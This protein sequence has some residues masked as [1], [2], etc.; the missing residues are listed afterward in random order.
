MENNLRKIKRLMICIFALLFVFG[1]KSE[2][3]KAAEDVI[4]NPIV[5]DLDGDGQVTSSDY[6]LMQ[7]FLLGKISSFPVE[8]RVIK[9]IEDM[10]VTINQF[11]S[12][13]LPSTISA[14]MMDGSQNDLPVKWNIG[15]IDTNICDTYEVLGTV[16]GYGKM[17]NL[18]VTVSPTI[19]SIDN[20]NLNVE[21]DSD[22]ILPSKVLAKL[23]DGSSKEVNVTW[24]NTVDTSIKGIFTFEGTV[25]NYLEKV[26]YIITIDDLND[27]GSSN[28]NLLNGGYVAYKD[29]Y[30]YYANP[31]DSGKLYKKNIDGS[32]VKLTNDINTS[33]INIV[34][35]W[36]Y[37]KYEDAVYKV[38]NDGTGRELLTSSY[39]IQDYGVK[40][41]TSYNGEVY[42]SHQNFLGSSMIVKIDREGI[43]SRICDT[44]GRNYYDFIADKEFIYYKNE[45]DN[46]RLYKIKTDGSENSIVI[47]DTNINNFDIV[48]ND[49]IYSTGNY[50]KKISLISGN[51]TILLYDDKLSMEDMVI[52]DG[53]IYFSNVGSDYEFSIY[54]LGLNSENKEKIVCIMDN[55]DGKILNISNDKLYILDYSRH[56]TSYMS[57]LDGS[58]LINFNEDRYIESVDS[59][60]FDVVEGER[61]LPQDKV[62]VHYNDGISMFKNVKW[63]TTD[64]NTLEIGTRIYNGT[65]DGYNGNITL[66]IN[67]IEDKRLGNKDN[68]KIFDYNGNIY[69]VNN[70]DNDRLY[71]VDASGKSIKVTNDSV[72]NV[73]IV[74]DWIYYCD[75][76]EG[77]IIKMKVDGSEK[78]AI[79]SGKATSLCMYDQW[80]Y[81]V[82]SGTVCKVD[83]DGNK[84]EKVIDNSEKRIKSIKMYGGIIYG[85]VEEIRGSDNSIIKKGELIKFSSTGEEINTL[86]IEKSIGEFTIHGGYLYYAYDHSKRIDS[87]FMEVN[88][89]AGLI[90]CV[91]KEGIIYQNYGNEGN[92][93]YITDL[94]GN[95]SKLISSLNGQTIIN[96]N[97]IGDWIYYSEHN[98]GYYKWYKIKL[99]GSE[100]QEIV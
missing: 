68:K 58:E 56:D 38:K 78:R 94:N 91:S 62:Y 42:Y 2:M 4:A 70:K 26:I 35:E 95:D 41:I 5:G 89:F 19:S 81:F 47:N 53:S 52:Y 24:N 48:D 7:Q 54:K 1:F 64:F 77:R 65:I 57:N 15:F 44:D 86:I 40:L 93:Y 20:K 21:L 9:S 3:V 67:V 33:Y 34:G 30:T 6:A 29:G 36:I 55:I 100:R 22:Y 59:L 23:S 32:F 63:D 17:V 71:R 45:N 66:K 13:M 69:F 28:S 12:Y 83:L 73:N 98:D 96:V 74:D 87:N 50:L 88:D 61:F 43:Q 31:L 16:D 14:L 76:L 27:R 39:N 72:Y 8:G 85:F 60:E 10:N 99:D 75:S 11:S 37:Y 46:G 25:E 92:I 49:I 51:E 79:Y 18:K 84:F 90:K 80:I 82:S 97:I